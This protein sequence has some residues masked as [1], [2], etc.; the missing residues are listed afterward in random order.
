ME[1]RHVEFMKVLREACHR[2]IHDASDKIDEHLGANDG[3]RFDYINKYIK[4]YLPKTVLV[5]PVKDHFEDLKKNYK[6]DKSDN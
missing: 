6:N 4:K 5:E 2:I 3:L 1:Q